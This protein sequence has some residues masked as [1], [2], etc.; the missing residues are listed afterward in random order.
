[1]STYG[2]IYALL[3]VHARTE[4]EEEVA[5]TSKHHLGVEVVRVEV[6]VVGELSAGG[7]VFQSKQRQTIHAVHVPTPSAHTVHQLI[8]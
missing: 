5:M 6:V 2:A 8:D 1:M 3:V 7:D 4:E